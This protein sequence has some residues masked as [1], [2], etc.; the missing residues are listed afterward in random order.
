MDR[1][2]LVRAQSL[3][4]QVIEILDD[5]VISDDKIQTFCFFREQDIID[6][7]AGAA[8]SLQYVLTTVDVIVFVG[9]SCQHS[10]QKID[11]DIVAPE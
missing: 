10:L 5:G 11:G 7:F 1:V 8:N 6:H 2:I 4:G 3:V 9:S